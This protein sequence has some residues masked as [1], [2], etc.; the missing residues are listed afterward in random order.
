MYY[1]FEFSIKLLKTSIQKKGTLFSHETRLARYGVGQKLPAFSFFA[2]KNLSG[3]ISKGQCPC[4]L[5]QFCNN[6]FCRNPEF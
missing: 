4:L 5:I 1:Q 3:I 2:K 6:Y